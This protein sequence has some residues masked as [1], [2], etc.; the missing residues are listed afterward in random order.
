MLCLMGLVNGQIQS[1]QIITQYKIIFTTSIS[2]LY[3]SILWS[4]ALTGRFLTLELYIIW[5]DDKFIPTDSKF[6]YELKLET[7]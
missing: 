2:I 7:D 3:F 1:I 5:Y 4:Q 6:L